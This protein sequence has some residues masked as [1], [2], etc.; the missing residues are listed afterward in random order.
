MAAKPLLVMIHTNVIVK[1]RVL[2]Y[3][4][5]IVNVAVVFVKKQYL[6]YNLFFLF[7]FIFVI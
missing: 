7:N 3:V 6:N 5:M 1:C 2:V 4:A